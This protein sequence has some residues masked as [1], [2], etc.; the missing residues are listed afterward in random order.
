M[1]DIKNTLNGLRKSITKTSTEIVKTTKINLN[2]SSSE[3]NLNSLYLE[4]GKKVHEIYIYGGTLGKFFDEKFIDIV[5][6]ERKISDLRSQLDVIKGTRSCYKCGG[7]V[8]RNSEFCPKCGVSLVDSEVRTKTVN[9]FAND[10][11][12]TATVK[13]VKSTCT[14]CLFEN[15]TNSKY[16]FSCGRQL[17]V[18]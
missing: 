14:L 5:E 16:C 18:R 13:T 17:N 6:L 15:D 9:E 1:S 10:N 2:I 7:Q 8:D 11:F 12:K 4:I 3:E